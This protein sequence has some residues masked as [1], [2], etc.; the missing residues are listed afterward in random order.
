MS[1]SGPT[2]GTGI[3]M[4]LARIPR[5]SVQPVTDDQWQMIEAMSKG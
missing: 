5:L 2:W 4:P 3:D 1:C